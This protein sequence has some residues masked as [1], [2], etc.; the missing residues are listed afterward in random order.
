MTRR[1]ELFRQLEPPPGGLALLR[2]RLETRRQRR[3][4]LV[5]V[6]AFAAAACAVLVLALRQPAPD[7]VREGLLADPLVHSLGLRPAQADVAAAEGQT[8]LTQVPSAN[9]HVAI[10]WVDAW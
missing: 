10:Y 5:G 2:E 1:S 3:A 4:W 8:A 9:P 6:P 7:P